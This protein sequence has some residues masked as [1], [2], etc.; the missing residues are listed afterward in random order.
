MYNIIFWG[1][2]HKCDQVEGIIKECVCSMKEKVLKD[3]NNIQIVE[4]VEI[5]PQTCND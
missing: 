4:I 2:Q 3:I 5:H 1:T